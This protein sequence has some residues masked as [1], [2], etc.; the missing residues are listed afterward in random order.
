MKIKQTSKDWAENRGATV[1]QAGRLSFPEFC[2]VF[3][4]KDPKY[5]LVYCNPSAESLAGK[6]V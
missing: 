4:W 3:G 1:G 2:K 6:L 5:A